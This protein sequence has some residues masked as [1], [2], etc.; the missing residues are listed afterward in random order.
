MPS[1]AD[2]SVPTPRLRFAPSPTGYLHVGGARTALFNWLYA[3]KYGGQFLLRIEDTDKAR[4]TEESTRAIF[5]GLEWLGLTWEEDVVYQGANLE[6]HRADAQRMLD[7]GTA[8]RCFCTQ[9]ELAE[10]R[11]E[12]EARKDS[13]KYDRRCDR[14]PADEV[15]RRVAAG[16]PFTVRFRVPEGTTSWDDLVH[17]E[18]AFPNKDIEDFIV[19]RTDGTPIYNLA[20]V[21]DDIAMRITV[22][23]RGDDHI[24]NTPKQIMLYRALGEEPPTFAHLPMIHGLDGKKLSKRHGATAVGDY[25]HLGI[26]PSAMLNFLALLGWSP[27]NDIE[28]MTQAQMIELFDTHGLQK[29]AAIFDPK[30]LE[31]MNGQHLSLIPAGE[32]VARVVPGMEAAGLATAAELEQRRDWFVALLDL[33]KVRART[34]DDVVRQAQPYFRGKITYDPDAVAKQWK[35]RVGTAEILVQARQTLAEVGKWE[36]VAMEEAL[37]VLAERMGFGEKAGRVFQPL[38]VALTGLMASPGIFDVLLILGRDRSLS[39]I[40]DAV[41]FLRASSGAPAA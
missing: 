36:P 28:V 1:P 41:A 8:Y 11:A 39:R 22:V 2:M 21:S 35:D 40:D 14:L 3:R 38:R 17:D 6:L 12:A 24:S 18:I 34:I 31:W 26:L 32:L 7:N 16:A 23:M 9:A 13:F 20:V 5:E 15:A 19:L 30:K 27:G 25:Q 33:L 37:R 29:K 10:R 4:S